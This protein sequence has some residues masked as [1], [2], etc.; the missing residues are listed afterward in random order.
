[1][2]FLYKRGPG[3]GTKVNQI[4]PVPTWSI[5]TSLEGLSMY[6]VLYKCKSHK[7]WIESLELFF[8]FCTGNFNRSCSHHV[9]C[10]F[11]HLLW[12]KKFIS[13]A[14]FIIIADIAHLT[15]FFFGSLSLCVKG[16]CDR[17]K[18]NQ[19]GNNI[20]LYCSIVEF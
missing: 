18:N 13:C 8:D 15:F 16:P 17:V 11:L 12:L 1:M 10:W 5:T 4:I 14:Q 7:V 6:L 19:I 2:F 3:D 20:S 9:R